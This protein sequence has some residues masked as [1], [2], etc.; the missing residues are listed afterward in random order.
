MER[1]FEWLSN[2]KLNAAKELPEPGVRTETGEAE[3]SDADR[4]GDV[5]ADG[6]VNAVLRRRSDFLG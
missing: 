5:L 4:G 2:P 1:L 3:Q 6:D